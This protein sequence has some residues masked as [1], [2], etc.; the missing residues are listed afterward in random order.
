MLA[1][2]VVAAVGKTA[3]ETLN[4]ERTKAVINTDNTP[5][6]EFVTHNNV[7]FHQEQVKKDILAATQKN[8]QYFVPASSYAMGLMGD[9]I[10]TNIF[11]LGYAWQLGLVPLKRESIERAIELNG[12]GIPA[13]KKS[14]NFGRLA[15]HNP[16]SIEKMMKDVHGD[17]QEEPAAQT[18]E[19]I[20]AKRVAY[21][22]SYQNAAYA[23]H[24]ATAIAGLKSAERSA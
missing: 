7:D 4:P 14:F 2:D 23:E 12:V 10:A 18:L 15:V 6:A 22:T 16:Q 24:Y 13:N 5:V 1:C 11:M 19:D 21:L 3:H 20:I 9:E 8:G 17:A